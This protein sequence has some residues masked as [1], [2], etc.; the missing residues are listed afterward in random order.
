MAAHTS[1][2]A[3][4][5]PTP[6]RAITNPLRSS[7]PSPIP[8]A[9]QLY[10]PLAKAVLRRRLTNRI[11]L[12]TALISLAGAFSWLLWIGRPGF[13]HVLG[14]S[15]A[16]WVGGV[17]PVILLRKVYL[18]VSHTSAPSP[19]LLVQ[20]SLA[21]PLSSRTLHAIQAHVFSALCVLAL[22]AAVDPKLPIF[23][24]SR[25]H[26]Y[27]PHPVLV[28]LALSQ[29]ALAM[30]YVLRAVL[31]DVW[32]FPF[33]RPTLTLSLG[34]VLAP[35]ILS[36]LALPIALVV[37]FVVIPIL[38]R[39]P[40]VSIL[41]RIVRPPHASVLRSLGRAW[42]LGI[43]TA[44]MWEAAGGIW[45]WVI[46]EHLHTTP[47]ARAFVSGISVA[48]TPA[49]APSAISSALSTPSSLSGRPSFLSPALP[50]STPI[51]EP[52]PV[53]IYTHLAYAELLAIA[54]ASDTNS[55]KAR[56]EVFDVDGA[57]WARLAREALVFL[58]R[59]Y[60]VLLGRGVVAAPPPRSA[61]APVQSPSASATSALGT[62]ASASARITPSPLIKQNIFA[63]KTPPS[64]AAR[65]RAALASGGA[66]EELVA[67]VVDSLPVPAIPDYL[68]RM[69][70]DWRRA[71]P[72]LPPW[73]ARWV[74]V[75]LAVSLPG[76]W[77]QPR[78]GRTVAGWVPRKEVCV[79]AVGVLTHL[80]CAS[81]AEDR[82][83]SVQRDIPRVLEAL[84]EFLGAVE[85]AQAEVR[86][87]AGGNG[88]AA[89]PEG[90]ADLDEARAVLGD[91]S[92]AL[93][94]GVARIVRTFGDKLRAFR[95]P[96]RTAARLQE[97]VDY[98]VQ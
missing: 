87:D 31:R 94:E 22:H 85:A 70:P 43:Q 61:P 55:A 16:L 80:T 35:I 89:T 74:H 72:R 18:T 29:C 77:T 21:P 97:Y 10:E 37:L 53:S 32:V 59:E 86:L 79:A 92:D 71:R 46:G 13:L 6:I 7:A 8:P 66:V 38:R 68:T 17:L 24:K 4:G 11:F 56:A 36:F 76:A 57:V 83:G 40:L 39:V 14:V 9:S 49:P 15:V 78:V 50:P 98:C 2:D 69:V 45:G 84:L 95:F 91:L 93:K 58:G 63:K 26:P 62:H 73:A 12:H 81:L 44:G 33:R 90:A 51:P 60:R 30:L 47:A 65:V 42:S 19:L 5:F 41:L 88:Q 23:I 67:P 52:K 3:T 75:A 27:T 20:K 25:K 34:T 28:L 54:S 1:R 48:V 96:P 82:F 64:P